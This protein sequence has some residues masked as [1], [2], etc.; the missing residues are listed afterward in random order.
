MKSCQAFCNEDLK[1][2]IF[3]EKSL[4]AAQINCLQTWEIAGIEAQQS[5][6]YRRSED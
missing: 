4:V 5:D 2:T 1:E 6:E 3:I